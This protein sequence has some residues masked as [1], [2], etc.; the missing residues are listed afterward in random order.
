[1]VDQKTVTLYF[2]HLFY[3]IIDDKFRLIFLFN[4]YNMLSF[5]WMSH[6]NLS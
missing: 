5:P 2:V 3:L 6:E 4:N 1:M